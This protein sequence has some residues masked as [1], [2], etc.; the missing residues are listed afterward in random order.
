MSRHRAA[1]ARAAFDGAAEALSVAVAGGEGRDDFIV[2]EDC[3]RVI[4][5]GV[6]VFVWVR[7]GASCGR[8]WEGLSGKHSQCMVT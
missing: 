2:D 1:V 8:D 7:L 3:L 5:A 4:A 6:V